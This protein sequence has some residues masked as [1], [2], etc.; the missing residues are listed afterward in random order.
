MDSSASG[1]VF[2]GFDILNTTTGRIMCAADFS[3]ASV[4]C[5]DSRYLP[6]TLPGAFVDPGAMAGFAPFNVS[7]INGSFYVA[8]AKQDAAKHDDVPGAGLGYIDVFDRTGTFVQRLVTGGTLNAPWAMLLAP[9]DLPIIG[10]DLLVGN[11]GDG[12]INVYNPT[13]GAF[14]QQIQDTSGNPLTIDGLWG[15]SFGP[16]IP[17]DQHLALFF[18]SGP[19][20]ETQGLVGRLDFAP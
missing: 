19:L 15:L 14:V 16:R 11:F 18:A 7:V 2:K 3:R 10:G 13:T 17:T 6:I 12:R 8:Y 9:S 4:D 20:M 1:A 5:F